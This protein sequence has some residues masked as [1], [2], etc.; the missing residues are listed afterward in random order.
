[1]SRRSWAEE[2]RNEEDVEVT[3][4]GGR[5]ERDEGRWR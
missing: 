1:M 5:G 4:E 2:G 3:K